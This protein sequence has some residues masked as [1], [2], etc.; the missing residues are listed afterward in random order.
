MLPLEKHTLG[1]R[2]DWYRAHTMA[3]P[4]ISVA[5]LIIS[6]LNQEK[7]AW[8]CKHE[9]QFDCGSALKVSTY[10]CVAAGATVGAACETNLLQCLAH[11]HTWLQNYLP[12]RRTAKPTPLAPAPCQPQTPQPRTY[13]TK[14]IPHAAAVQLTRPYILAGASRQSDKRLLRHPA[15]PFWALE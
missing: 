5:V 4:A 2:C 6:K 3:L 12:V 7:H 15:N 9:E 10:I 1:C 11:S 13:P 8:L 14:I